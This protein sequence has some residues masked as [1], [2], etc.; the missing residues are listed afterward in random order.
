MPTTTTI[1]GLLATMAF[2]SPV[3]AQATYPTRPVT[4]IV[5]LA[6]GSGPDVA[7]RILAERLSQRLG[8]PFIVD[9]R[10]G[11]A[12]VA[13]IMAVKSAAADGYTLGLTTSAPMAIRPAMYRK[14]PYDPVKDFTPIALYAKSP[15]V[16][17]VG[18]ALPVKTVQELIAYVRGNGGKTVFASSSVGG[19]P[20]LAGEYM[21]KHFNLQMRHAPYSNSPQ[22]FLDV[23]AG[24]VAMSFADV[25]TA[26]PLIEGG[27]LRALAVT[28]RE[29]LESLPAVPPFAQA[30]GATDFEV[31]SWHLIY[32][33]SDTP[34][35]I[36]DRLH[37]ELKAIMAEP[38]TLKKIKALGL[39]PQAVSEADVTRAYVKAESDKW[40]AFVKELGLAGTL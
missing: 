3:M 12:Q 24:H 36:V 27:K 10:P 21:R 26:L 17:V 11:N 5:P 40:G 19:P 7:A 30:S 22:A 33:R 37:A 39:I 32:A 2:M 8:K 28:S 20:H 6:A 35:P 29:P 31:V 14:A 15:F 25:G 13:A 18:P 34:K 9:N 4:I 16:L 38:D 1:L 23:S